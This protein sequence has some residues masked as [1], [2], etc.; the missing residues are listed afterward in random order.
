MKE[1]DKEGVVK[2]RREWK[3]K[4]VRKWKWFEGEEEE[5]RGGGGGRIYTFPVG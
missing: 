2:K 1:G 4:K 5:G 3:R